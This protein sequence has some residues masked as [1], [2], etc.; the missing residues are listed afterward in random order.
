MSHLSWTRAAYILFTFAA[1]TVLLKLHGGVADSRPLASRS[2]ERTGATTTEK[3]RI[4]ANGRVRV[5]NNGNVQRSVSI[6]VQ[7]GSNV[8]KESTVI[9]GTTDGRKSK[10]VSRTADQQENQAERRPAKET[11][12]SSSSG[13]SSQGDPPIFRRPSFRT[14]GGGVGYAP[15]VSPS[16][17][18]V[19][20]NLG[21]FPKSSKA[22]FPLPK[23]YLNSYDDT[24]GAPRTQGAH[25]GT[26]LM[27]PSGTPEYAITDGTLVPVSGSNAD[28]W[29]TL[30][31]Y[32]MM[33]RADYSIGPIHAGDLFYYAHMDRKSPLPIGTRVRAGQV[34]GVAGDT[35]QGPE[36]TRGIFPSHLHLGWYDM[37]GAR[38]NLS[39]GAMNP[40]P[41]LQWLK[42]N[43]GTVAGGSKASYCIAPQ[44]D[45]PVPSTGKVYW[46][47]SGYPGRQPDL[48]TGTRKAAPSPIF[49][50]ILKRSSQTSNQQKTQTTGQGA[51]SGQNGTP[52]QNKPGRPGAK[53]EKPRVPSHPTTN[54]NGGVHEKPHPKPSAN[55]EKPP[56]PAKPANP[57]S[58]NPPS[59]NDLPAINV[60]GAGNG[61]PHFA[62]G[63]EFRRW[64]KALIQKSTN[65]AQTKK[66][67]PAFHKPKGQKGHRNTAAKHENNKKREGGEKRKPEKANACTKPANDE[68]CKKDTPGANSPAPK[69]EKTAPE[70]VPAPSP[71]KG[72]TSSPAP[73]SLPSDSAGKSTTEVTS[74]EP[75]A[76]D[77][78][79][80]TVLPATPEGTTSK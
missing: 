7:D 30:G 42:T 80:T 49:E 70:S 8:R 79:A 15:T 3:P 52:E 71:P 62:D 51:A 32:A 66:Q 29:N 12:A 54:Q 59:L 34:L 73:P 74:P 56:R 2:V 36:G 5:L 27:A 50:K 9:Q 23:N 22:I 63:A 4:T 69:V 41:L 76:G 24:W 40:Y 46:P 13:S 57:A 37:S 10:E 1:L 26:D 47:S 11:S 72:E 48:D 43:G 21:N 17:G 75:P 45:N 64:L 67:K 35:G 19:C 31:G 77:T 78:T 53:P 28:G 39:S 65:R 16:S 14:P 6:V 60:P 68:T 18:P 33:L 44:R 61:R 58:A 55:P 20:G 25:E 38:T